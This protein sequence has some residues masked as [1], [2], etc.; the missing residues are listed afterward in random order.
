MAELRLIPEEKLPQDLQPLVLEVWAESETPLFKL[1]ERLPRDLAADR[2]DRRRFLLSGPW[3][4]FRALLQEHLDLKFSKALL[5]YL[6]GLR[7]DRVKGLRPRH[8]VIPPQDLSLALLSRKEVLELPPSLK[9][10]HLYFGVE[11]Q[12]PEVLALQ[13]LKG[14]LPFE[15]PGPGRLLLCASLADLL[16][17]LISPLLEGGSPLREGAQRLWED[18]KREVPDCVM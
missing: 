8:G 2:L 16:V 1:F 6:E 13:V 5:V 4:A 12:G 9:A 3:M 17:H 11:F 7:P 18:L 14:R 15:I 10:R